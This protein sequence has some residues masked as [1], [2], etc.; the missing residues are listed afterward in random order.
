MLM[1]IC[2]LIPGISGGTIAFITGIYTRFIHSVKGFLS[3]SVLF[4]F[5]VLHL[6]LV[7]SPSKKHFRIVSKF[8]KKYDLHFLFTLLFGML[9]SIFVAS[10]IILLE[11]YFT[12]TMSF[13]VGIISSSSFLIYS[14]IEERSSIGIVFS[15][16][17]LLCGIFL[18]FIVPI[19]PE[20][21]YLYVFFSGIIASFAM[22]LP[23]ISGSYLL[24]LLGSYQFILVSL[25]DFVVSYLF[26]FLCG[27]ILGMFFSSRIISTLLKKHYSAMLYLFFGFVLGALVIPLRDITSVGMTF[28]IV[29]SSIISFFIGVILVSLIEVLHRR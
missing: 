25:N 1:G 12:V 29:F 15:G 10:R 2:D 13:F 21:T 26:V 22:F 9:V 20:M 19:N 8:Y 5:V 4:E 7:V 28:G 18:V 14:K 24:Y 16:I 11:S 6:S 17:G 27:I 23:G 3:L